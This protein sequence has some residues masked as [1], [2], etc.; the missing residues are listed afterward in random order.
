MYDSK[1]SGGDLDTSLTHQL[2]LVYRAMITAEEDEDPHLVVH[3]PPVQQQNG[4]NDCGVFAI[5]FAVH[6]ALG[7]DIRRLEFDQ[8]QMRDHL[9]WGTIFYAVGHCST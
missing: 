1:F 7:D 5:A 2:A 6:A 3:V 9:L 8:N 4:S